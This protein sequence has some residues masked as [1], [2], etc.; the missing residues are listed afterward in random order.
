MHLVCSSFAYFHL[1]LRTIRRSETWPVPPWAW[2]WPGCVLPLSPP[3]ILL[4]VC[5]LL[6]RAPLLTRLPK[7]IHLGHQ[8]PGAPKREKN[9]AL[10]N[11]CRFLDS[12]IQR[13]TLNSAEMPLFCLMI[14]MRWPVS[15]RNS[16][17]AVLIPNTSGCDSIGR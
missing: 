6:Q 17:V 3:L 11:F 10:I 9:S 4:R 15:P 8:R 1:Q 7:Q 5:S 2:H 16:S 13:W 14:V 12:E